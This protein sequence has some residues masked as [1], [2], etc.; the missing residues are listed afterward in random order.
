MKVFPILYQGIDREPGWPIGIEWDDLEFHTYAIELNHGQTLGALAKRGGL[1]PRELFAGIKSL[2]LD[3]RAALPA[4][5]EAAIKIM[6]RWPR[7]WVYGKDF[8]KAH[9]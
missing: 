7:A 2:N 4:T 5:D 8:V 1:S 6:M 3:D 9:D